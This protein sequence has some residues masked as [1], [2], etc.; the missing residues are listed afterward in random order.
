[1]IPLYKDMVSQIPG[2]V[3]L[4][5]AYGG[6]VPPIHSVHINMAARLAKNAMISIVDDDK[7]VREAA[8]MLIGSL[9]YATATFASAEE[10][11]ESGRLRD[12]A[13]VITDVQMPGMSGVDLQSHLTANGHCT[14]MIFVT[15][16]PE[17]SLRARAMNGGA[18]GFLSKPFSED[19]LIACLDRAMEH[20]R[21]RSR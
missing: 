10:F 5:T 21:S 11:L 18:F 13:C 2:C 1:V 6:A 9:G 17:E 8:K 19:S 14:P 16:Y 4:L 12:T 7:S 3:R 20:Y 15:A